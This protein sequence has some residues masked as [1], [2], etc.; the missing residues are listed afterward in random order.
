MEGGRHVST[1]NER[2]TSRYRSWLHR[3]YV[4]VVAVSLRFFGVGVRIRKNNEY[5]VDEE[6]S[7][8][9]HVV[10]MKNSSTIVVVIRGNHVAAMEISW[11]SPI[12][13]ILQ[14][15]RRARFKDRFLILVVF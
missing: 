2:V 4:F 5:T 8:K 11:L 12:V 1:E 6:T 13:L 14:L 10:T 9:S 15:L 7:W 3:R